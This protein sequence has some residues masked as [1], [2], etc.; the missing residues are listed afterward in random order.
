[1]EKEMFHGEGDVPW[2]KD[3]SMEKKTLTKISHSVIMNQRILYCENEIA[4]GRGALFKS[5]L[6]DMTDIEERS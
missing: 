6:Q 4:Y 3:G 5:R 1:M 2:R